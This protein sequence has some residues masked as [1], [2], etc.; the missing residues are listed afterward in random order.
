MKSIIYNLKRDAQT[1]NKNKAIAMGC[2]GTSSAYWWETKELTDETFAL[3]VDQDTEV[4]SVY[5][6]VNY[7]EDGVDYITPEGVVVEL[8]EDMFPVVTGI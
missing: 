1:V 6:S 7:T 3:I 2:N 5:P 8:S 4:G